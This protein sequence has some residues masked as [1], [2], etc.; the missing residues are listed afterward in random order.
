MPRRE[1]TTTP[2]TTSANPASNDRRPGSGGH[3]ARECLEGIARKYLDAL[4]QRNPSVAPLADHAG[5]RSD[6]TRA[7]LD[8]D[9]VITDFKLADGTPAGWR[10]REAL[11]ERRNR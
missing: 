5:T 2:C 8:D 4:Q 7:F 11:P 3:C 6:L 9:A 1:I 10:L